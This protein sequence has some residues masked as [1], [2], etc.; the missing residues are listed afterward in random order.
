MAA[1]IIAA[2]LTSP[3][4]SR[5]LARRGTDARPGAAPIARRGED[6][7]GLV[8]GPMRRFGRIQ[9]AIDASSD[10]SCTAFEAAALRSACGRRPARWPCRPASTG[11]P[12]TRRLADRTCAASSRSPAPRRAPPGPRRSPARQSRASAISAQRA[13]ANPFPGAPSSCLESTRT[14]SKRDPCSRVPARP[15]NRCAPCGGSG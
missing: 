12:D 2:L 10:P 13:I 5:W 1:M 14:S 4:R 15:A 6:L 7:H 11:S 9:F 8:G 3:D